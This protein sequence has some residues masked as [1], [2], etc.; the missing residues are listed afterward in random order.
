MAKGRSKKTS[1][2]AEPD[3]PSDTQDS[4]VKSKKPKER[5]KK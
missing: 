2:R 5:R 1:K 4:V 3:T